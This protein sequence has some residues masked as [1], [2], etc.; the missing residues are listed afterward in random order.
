[1]SVYLVV[2]TV[3]LCVVQH[4]PSAMEAKECVSHGGQHTKGMHVQAD[5]RRELERR[6]CGTVVGEDG[7]RV[8]R[9]LRR[10]GGAGGHPRGRRGSCR[11]QRLQPAELPMPQ[12]TALKYR[13]S[14]LLGAG[15]LPPPP[16]PPPLPPPPPPPLLPTPE[17]AQDRAL[18]SI[19]LLASPVIFRG[20]HS[21]MPPTKEHIRLPLRF[22]SLP[23]LRTHVVQLIACLQVR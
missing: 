11:R 13:Q 16:P 18:G 1:M 9:S 14:N 15:K 23:Q 8:R 2:R 4:N 21:D 20:M 5:A 22:T 12:G 17:L 3:F 6:I 19:G 10:A 7:A